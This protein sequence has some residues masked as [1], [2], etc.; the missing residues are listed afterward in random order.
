MSP[1]T[2][3]ELDTMPEA[4]LLAL[5]GEAIPSGRLTAFFTRRA[6][7][8]HQQELDELALERSGNSTRHFI[9]FPDMDPQERRRR[10]EE[11]QRRALQAEREML[12]Y[13]ERADRL[14]AKIEEQ[15]RYLIKRRQEIE[16]RALRLHDG[17]RVYVDGDQ[18]RDEQGNILQGRDRDEAAG[19]HRLHPEAS[20]WRDK[21]DIDDQFA[22]AEKLKQKVLK[23]RAAVERGG[24]VQEAGGRLSG[25]EKELA[26]RIEAKAAQPAA[27]YGSADYRAELGGD[28]KISTV[29]AFT[30][31]AHIAS[32]ETSDQPSDRDGET[33]ETKKNPLP[34]GQCGLK[35]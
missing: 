8:L 32:P 26:A 23:D 17:R 15:Q 19:E 20:T 25:Y 2:E 18:Y 5:P 27:D 13:Q 24:G 22:E 3:D 4:E 31:A 16:D 34:S 28:W 33:E 12:E 21:Q 1:K 9:I 35:L 30:E 14:L 10:E 6:A 7:L 11:E 29:P